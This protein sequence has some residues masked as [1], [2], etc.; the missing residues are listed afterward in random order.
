VG[1]VL[2][3]WLGLQFPMILSSKIDPV[4]IYTAAAPEPTL[5]Y[6]L[7]AL[8]GGSAI[9]FPALGYLLMVF[10][11]SDRSELRHNSSNMR[12]KKMT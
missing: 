1:L 11:L 5:R 12:L 8:I 4:T 6:L 3:G 10:K 7:Y 2:I 9:I